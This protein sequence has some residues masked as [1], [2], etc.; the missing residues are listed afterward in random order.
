MN[1]L[2]CLLFD[3]FKGKKIIEGRIYVER[4]KRQTKRTLNICYYLYIFQRKLV[5]NLI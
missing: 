1:D 2:E 5:L 3:R 4:V